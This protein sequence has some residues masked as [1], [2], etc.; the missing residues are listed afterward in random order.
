MVI[1]LFLISFLLGRYPVTP[2]MVVTILGVSAG[3]GFGASLGMILY[4]PWP[5]VQAMA[6]LFA[7]LAVTISFLISRF[8]VK[9]LCWSWFWAAWLFRHFFRHCFQLPN[10]WQTAWTFCRQSPSG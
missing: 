1:V 9:I 6:F 8:L 7:M 5:A 3:A 10:I 2:D 4:Y